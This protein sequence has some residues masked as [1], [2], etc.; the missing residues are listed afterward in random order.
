MS[1]APDTDRTRIATTGE[2]RS[3]ERTSGPAAHELCLYVT[4]R[5]THA[6]R[7]LSNLRA[8]LEDTLGGR[9]TLE[10]IDVLEEPQRAAAEKILA[11]PTLVRRRP[12]PVRRIIGDFSD[13]AKVLQGL[14]IAP[15][16]AFPPAS[17]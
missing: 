17:G 3:R 7:S 15:A 9:F 1:D 16:E 6:Q 10:V 13:R 2:G 14:D 8:I 12:E 5:T 4:G 11:T